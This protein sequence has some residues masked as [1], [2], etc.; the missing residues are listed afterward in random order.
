ML[1]FVVGSVLSVVLCGALSVAPSTFVILI[2][3]FYQRAFVVIKQNGLTE[4][5]T[6]KI[7]TIKAKHKWKRKKKRRKKCM[8]ILNLCLLGDLQSW[9][10]GIIVLVQR[11]T[12]ASYN[13]TIHW[14]LW[15]T[16]RVKLV[17]AYTH[18]TH[19][20]FLAVNV[21]WAAA[22]MAGERLMRC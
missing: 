18:S 15:N 4:K 9:L 1:N 5:H 14:L 13:Q 2:I 12:T 21:E 20:D 8:I 11:I 3:L 6:H 7:E 17:S 19:S 16:M 10:V 22:V